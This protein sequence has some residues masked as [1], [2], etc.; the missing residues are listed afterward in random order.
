MISEERWD[1]FDPD[2]HQSDE[3][4]SAIYAELSSWSVSA[5]GE[6]AW[7][8]P[9]SLELVS[10]TDGVLVFDPISISTAYD[11]LTL[12]IDRWHVHLRDMGAAK[13]CADAKTY[14]SHWLGGQMV[15]LS[16]VDANGQPVAGSSATADNLK[17]KLAELARMRR[18]NRVEVRRS[19]GQHDLFEVK[20]RWRWCK[21]KL[22]PMRPVR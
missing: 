1:A 7:Q 18:S 3:W 20:R 4:S 22:V 15:V 13:A 5:H 10:R 9:G 12:S 14:V 19:S 16:A 11:Q 8:E 2:L 17:Q 21:P 6:W